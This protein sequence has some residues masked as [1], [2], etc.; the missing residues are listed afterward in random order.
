ML[1][2]FNLT[3]K[4]EDFHSLMNLTVQY[5]KT[6]TQS[7]ACPVNTNTFGRRT[8]VNRNTPPSV[9]LVALQFDI[10]ILL[11]LSKFP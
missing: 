10:L 9:T 2:K 6:A 3:I 11:L 7:S 5:Q 4:H 1:T 8:P